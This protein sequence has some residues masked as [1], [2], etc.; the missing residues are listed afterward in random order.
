MMCEGWPHHRGPRPPTLFEQWC[1]FF[2]VSRESDD[3]GKS[4][5]T[6]PTVFLPYPSR[7]ES[8]TVCTCHYKGSTFFSV[9]LKDPECCSDR[10]LNS[11]PPAYQTGAL[12]SFRQPRSEV[13][14]DWESWREKAK[15]WACVFE[16]GGGCGGKRSFT[17][18]RGVINQGRVPVYCGYCILPARRSCKLDILMAMHITNKVGWY[19]LTCAFFHLF[20]Q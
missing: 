13:R 11:R 6:G 17:E 9:I 3:K 12:Q 7:L 15:G 14:E 2:Y 16:W 5:E 20:I 18:V 19:F 1:G 8:L 10:G 4:F